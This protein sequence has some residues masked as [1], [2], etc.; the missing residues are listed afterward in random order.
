MKNFDKAAAGITAV[1]FLAFIGWLSL[2][3]AFPMIM[4]PI[5]MTIMIGTLLYMVYTCVRLFQHANKL[6][7]L[8]K[9]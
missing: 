3:I 6:D 9:E 4:E 1:I 5:N 7:K 8:D 2:S